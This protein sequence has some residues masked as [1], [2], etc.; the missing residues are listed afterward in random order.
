MEKHVYI[1]FPPA[2]VTKRSAIDQ[3][4]DNLVHL[5]C[6]V[7]LQLSTVNLPTWLAERL[8]TVSRLPSMWRQSWPCSSKQIL[9]TCHT[10]DVSDPRLLCNVLSRVWRHCR[11]W[12]MGAVREH[13]RIQFTSYVYLKHTGR[14][15]ARHHLLSSKPVEGLLVLT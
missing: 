11:R 8:R 4:D 3:S 13:A 5:C 9:C 15:R 14:R 6:K 10:W 1:L 12:S 2:R 7:L